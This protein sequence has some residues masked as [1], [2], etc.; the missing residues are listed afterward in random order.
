MFA[1]WSAGKYGTEREEG[2][3]KEGRAGP[4]QRDHEQDRCLSMMISSVCKGRTFL[5]VRLR[6]LTTVF[7][8]ESPWSQTGSELFSQRM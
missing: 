4:G 3:S 1:I 8:D 2:P 5:I 6:R 7:H